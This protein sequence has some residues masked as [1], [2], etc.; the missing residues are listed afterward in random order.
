[1]RILA[2]S[3]SSASNS[4]NQALLECALGRLSGVEIDR[5]SVRDLSA[6]VF[7]TD[8]EAAEGVPP[9]MVAFHGR[10]QAADAVVLASP[11]HNG[12]PPAMLKNTIDWASRVDRQNKWLQKPLVLLS[13]SP[14]PGGGRHNLENLVKFTP[15]YG[16]EVVGSF[17]LPR[18]HQA[19]DLAGGRVRDPE[20]QAALDALMNAL[21]A[22]LA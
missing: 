6:P 8:V 15:R 14:G 10:V 3:G 19:F 5:V 2:L 18:F 4:I 9:D 22:R 20:Q 17:F 16:A 7:S 11:E 21:A 13:T 1:M 12:F